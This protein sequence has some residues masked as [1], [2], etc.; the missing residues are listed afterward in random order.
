MLSDIKD[1]GE[2]ISSATTSAQ[3]PGCVKAPSA[4]D[5]STNR[6]PR[7][8]PAVLQSHEDARIESTRQSDGRKGS[9]IDSSAPSLQLPMQQTHS[10]RPHL[11]SG[12]RHSNG[13]GDPVT[14]SSVGVMDDVADGK[15]EDQEFMAPFQVQVQIFRCF[16]SLCAL[17]SLFKAFTAIVDIAEPFTGCILMCRVFSQ[18]CFASQRMDLVHSSQIRS[19]I[20]AE[21]MIHQH[22]YH[23]SVISSSCGTVQFSAVI[24]PVCTCNGTQASVC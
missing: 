17:I 24:L 14:L 20:G 12:P 8:V 23:K 18:L 15:Q 21:I 4:S 22:Y 3:A 19:Q 5:A 1:A 2:D 6:V 10:V 7:L 11:K 9:L 13:G 16:F